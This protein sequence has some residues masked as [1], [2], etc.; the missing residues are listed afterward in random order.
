MP[1][2]GYLINCGNGLLMLLLTFVWR[3]M[4]VGLA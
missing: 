4:L 2:V 1:I 3:N